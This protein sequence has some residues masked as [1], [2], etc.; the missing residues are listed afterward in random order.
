MVDNNKVEE[1]KKV[2][3]IPKYFDELIIPEMG[4]YYDDYTVDFENRP[5][6][7]CPLHGEDTPSLRWYDDTNTFYCFGCRAGGDVIN[8]HRLFTSN[9]TGEQPT[10][11]EAID[12]LYGYFI[13][14]KESTEIF[15]QG[16]AVQKKSSEPQISSNT[17]ILRLASYVSNLEETLM[18]DKTISEQRRLAIYNAID[19]VNLLC[20]LNR[21]NAADGLKYIKDV[22]KT[23]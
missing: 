16:K 22:V 23:G 10:F 9:I 11:E 2:V 7:K 12:F 20:G 3:S 21:L 4:S 19:N 17:E 8:L 6:V 1:I 5:V 13:K 15:I 18:I 14:G